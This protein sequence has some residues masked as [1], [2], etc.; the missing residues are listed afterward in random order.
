M[1]NNLYIENF[2]CFAQRTKIELGKITVCAGMN[3]V[4]KSSLIQ[5]LLLIRQIYEDSVKYRGTNIDEYEIELNG[6]YGLQLGNSQSIKSSA[7]EDDIFLNMDDF[8]FYLRS[9][10]LDQEKNKLN[11]PMKMYVINPYTQGEL[12]TEKGV[13]A[14][15]FYYLNAERLGPRSYQNISTSNQ[16]GCGIHGENTFYY[17]NR[18]QLD[19]IDEERMFPFDEDKRVNT[20]NKQIEYWMDYIIPGIELNVNELNELG[21]SQMRIRQQVFDTGFMTPYNFGFGISYVLPI[22]ASGLLIPADCMLI[23]E[24]PEAH[25]HPA[26]QSRIGFFLAA[27]AKAGVQIVLETHSEHVI[28]GIRI[29]GLKMA[30]PPED[31]CINYFSIDYSVGV[32]TVERVKLNERMDLLDWP[33]GFMDQEEQDLRTLRE[34]RKKN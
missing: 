27:M 20:A 26:G 5:S 30:V 23:V 14:D 7:D 33:D 1:N 3:S 29:A 16:L 9:S 18:H 31:I 22:I 24:N 8:E 12:G 2:K 13:F 4:G 19:R 34:L 11:S 25:L 28:N 17:I 21:I 15:S 6:I 32:H 10:S